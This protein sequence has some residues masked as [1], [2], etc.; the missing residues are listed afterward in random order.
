MGLPSE[1]HSWV[2]SETMLCDWV[3]LL[4][5]IPGWMRL[6]AVLCDWS[7]YCLNSAWARPQSVFN[8]QTGLCVELYCRV[9]FVS[10]PSHQGVT[11]GWAL[12]LL[13]VT[14]HIP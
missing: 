9:G 2:G 7:G 14:V 13:R 8:N 5:E 11:I 12:R 1:T 4:S 6:Q 3:R 10:W